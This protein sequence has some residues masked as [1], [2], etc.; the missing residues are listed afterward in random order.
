[1][2]KEGDHPTPFDITPINGLAFLYGDVDGE[3]NL[4]VVDTTTHR[5]YALADDHQTAELVNMTPLPRGQISP[6]LYDWEGTITTKS[7][8]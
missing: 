4:G 5:G 8:L 1:M 2:R 6:P 3:Q 7:T